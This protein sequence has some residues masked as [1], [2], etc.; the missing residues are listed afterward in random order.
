MITL[1]T[2]AVCTALS[3]TVGFAYQTK[4]H[5]APAPVHFGIVYHTPNGQADAIP[6]DYNGITF[7]TET[8]GYQFP[9]HSALSGEWSDGTPV[10][11]VIDTQ[12][13]EREFGES[14]YRVRLMPPTQ[15]DTAGMVLFWSGDSKV[16]LLPSRIG[17]I[18]S[19]MAHAL[20]KRARHLVRL[21]MPEADEA[22]VDDF[23]TLLVDRPL[24]LVTQTGLEAIT[25]RVQLA[26]GGKVSDDRGMTF[27][28][29]DQRAGRIL[30]QNFGHPEWSPRAD[31]V[32]AIYPEAFFT[33]EGDPH[34]YLVAAISGAWESRGDWV[35]IDATT[36]RILTG[37][38]NPLAEK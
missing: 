23:D 6:G 26:K 33:V 12:N 14:L 24:V 4:T 30:L 13:N 7:V 36:G 16:H 1:R 21:A 15:R 22:M 3:L 18:D 10:Q 9:L 38:W 34:T 2:A 29:Y 17:T 19:A 20:Q 37:N 35:M 27:F 28:L 5:Q 32:F 31:S 25:Y 8:S 11:V